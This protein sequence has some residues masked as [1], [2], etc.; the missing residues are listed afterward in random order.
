MSDKPADPLSLARVHLDSLRARGLSDESIRL[1]SLHTE[2]DPEKLRLMLNREFPIK[3]MGIVIPF[4]DI[5]GSPISYRRVRWLPTWT[6]AG[7]EEA[8]YDQ[9]SEVATRV[10]F[11][12][13]V[14]Q[15][16]EDAS[17]PIIITEGEF[18]AIAADQHGIASIGIC[19]VGM[20]SKPREKDEPK[21]TPRTLHPDLLDITWKD[22]IVYIGFDSDTI[23]KTGPAKPSPNSRSTPHWKRNSSIPRSASA[24]AK[25]S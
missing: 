17:T 5:T 20:W 9:P 25:T 23:Y 18:K 16:R 19:G 1:A 21:G 8:R 22:R 11:P 2:R 12:P 4:F 6:R 24:S 7:G 13:R 3:Q 10:Y 15:V 14:R